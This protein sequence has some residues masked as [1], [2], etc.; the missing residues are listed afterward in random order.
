[1][2]FCFNK[3]YYYYFFLSKIECTK[4]IFNFNFISK[5]IELYSCYLI[6]YSK[7]KE[8]KSIINKVISSSKSRSSFLSVSK[9]KVIK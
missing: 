8:E 5:K 6:R 2:L 3:C 1:M 4:S 9:E 7:N